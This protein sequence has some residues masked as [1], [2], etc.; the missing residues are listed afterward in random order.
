MYKKLR[1]Y[2]LTHNIAVEDLCK[3]IGITDI[4]NY[5]R[6]EQGETDFKLEEAKDI[7]NLLNVDM[8]IFEK[9]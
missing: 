4:S 1:D 2:R 5:Y 6:R 3:V 9:S 7:C 8:D